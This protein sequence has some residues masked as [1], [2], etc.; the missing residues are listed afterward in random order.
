MK[1]HENYVY[2]LVLIISVC[3]LLLAAVTRLMLVI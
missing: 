2:Y 3:T 1:K